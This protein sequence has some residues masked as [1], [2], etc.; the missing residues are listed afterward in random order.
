MKKSIV[1]A[2]VFI[3]VAIFLGA[4]YWKSQNAA[5][6]RFQDGKPVIKVGILYPMSGNVAIFGEAAKTALEIFQEDSGER[7][8]DKYAYQFIFEDSQLKN[9][10]AAMG[11]RK[12]I[13]LDRAD[14][15]L[16][17]IYGNVSA[18]LANEKKVLHFTASLDPQSARGDYAFNITTSA[19]TLAK[20]MAVELKKNNVASV[21]II[22]LDNVNTMLFIDRLKEVAQG[23][24][25]RDIYRFNP[26]E[27]NFDTMVVKA[28]RGRP[29]M[30]LVLGFPPETDI[31]MRRLHEKKNT[32]PVS[33]F[34]S[35]TSLQE[36][37][38]AEGYWYVDAGATSSDFIRKYAAKT[39]TDI[40][41]YADF[42]YAMMQIVRNGYEKAA[43]AEGAD[44]PDSLDV[45]RA[46]QAETDG[47]ETVI[48]KVSIDAEGI[49]STP[50]SLKTIENG[51]IVRLD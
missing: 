49:V 46:I 2:V 4:L 17:M 12:L 32:I 1:L 20:K 23:V 3:C 33:T 19:A 50:A 39:G 8:E 24:E 34:E 42:M 9:A 14:V 27:R 10:R 21:S 36:R 29:D 25:I 37:G 43:L 48:G 26:G 41:N 18:P 45:A 15:V 40:L 6:V 11:V 7:K 22:T 13:D 47:M 28:M 44:K 16:T 51:P 30:L 35:F 38:L 31:I 5:V